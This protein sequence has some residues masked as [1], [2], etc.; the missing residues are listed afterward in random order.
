M[1]T[2]HNYKLACYMTEAVPLKSLAHEW[3]KKKWVVISGEGQG[4]N[5]VYQ[6]DSIY[7]QRQLHIAVA[8]QRSKHSYGFN[9]IP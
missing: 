3:F 2:R 5:L 9:R 4:Y 7:N 6:D 8:Y 1:A